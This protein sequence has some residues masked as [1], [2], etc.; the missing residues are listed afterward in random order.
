MSGW[1][2]QTWCFV[3][4]LL[5][6][7]QAAGWESPLEISGPSDSERSTPRIT[8]GDNGRLFVVYLDKVAGAWRVYFREKSSLGTWDAQV[9]QLS[10]PGQFSVRPDVVEDSL[11][12]PHVVFATERSSAYDLYHTYRD[13]PDWVGG[14]LTETGEFEDE[15]RLAN[16]LLGRIHL[17]YTRGVVESSTGDVLYRVWTP[18]CDPQPCG[19]WSGEVPL[20]QVSNAYYHRPDIVVDALGNIHVVWIS[21]S[22]GSYKV[23]YRRRTSGIWGATIDI[24]SGASSGHFFNYPRIATA[25]LTQIAVVWHDDASGGGSNILWNHSLNGGSSWAFAPSGS[26][27]GQVLHAGH[28]PQ[29][30]SGLPG[31][32][33]VHLI[34]NQEPGQTRLLYRQWAGGATW[35]APDEIYASSDWKGW[36]DIAEDTNGVYHAVWDEPYG[37]ETW[38]HF[39]AYSSSAPDTTPPGPVTGFTAAA[40][41]NSVR[42]TWTNPMDPDFQKTRICWSIVNY[43]ADPE[44]CENPPIDRPD[45]PGS[46]DTVDHGDAEHPLLNGTT[47]YYS[48]FAYDTGNLHS[49]GATAQ[50]TP[51][52]PMD[53][54]RDVDVDQSDFGKMQTCLGNPIPPGCNWADFNLDN[55]VNATDMG[56]F[57]DCWSG[58]GL[59]YVPTCAD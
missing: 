2:S 52:I 25:S 24:G 30:E 34:T 32:G 18:P 31:T 35:T 5:L 43:P 4:G 50:A 8:R 21:Q 57:I 22:G 16:D 54:D 19:G 14:F 40:F 1:Q 42:L 10:P 41:H 38:Q 59:P 12:R 17:V 55:A 36:P 29:L 7:G 33:T 58:P 15:P 23:R 53:D 44:T 20:G 46:A 48:A 49:V 56:S 11:H 13:G 6:A 45:V 27:Q 37:A 9:L 51:F 47:Y 28:Y 39:I 26:D 3:G